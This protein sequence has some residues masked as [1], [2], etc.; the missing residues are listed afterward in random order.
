[1]S[2]EEIIKNMKEDIDRLNNI[3]HL[4]E[5]DKF[6]KWFNM[7]EVKEKVK[8]ISRFIRFIPKRKRK[9]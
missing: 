6:Y 2:E 9:E 5:V 7:D 8:K 4:S 1:M 3:I